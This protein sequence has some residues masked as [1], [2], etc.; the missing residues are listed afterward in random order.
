MEMPLGRHQGHHGPMGAITRLSAQRDAQAFATTANAALEELRALLLQ[1]RRLGLFADGST[2]G[3]G[4]GLETSDGQR[5]GGDW[6]HP[7]RSI[8]R[9][10]LSAAHRLEDIAQD[11]DAGAPIAVPAMERMRLSWAVVGQDGAALAGLA[12]TN[13]N[14]AVA[15]AESA[16][17]QDIGRML[18]M[19]L[20]RNEV[21]WA[22]VQADAHNLLEARRPVMNA[23]GLALLLGAA[24]I[25]GAARYLEQ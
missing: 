21:S 23:A 25:Y 11:L 24:A 4:D 16:Q 15:S 1:G 13:V 14:Q 5:L 22:G 3:N 18:Y 6:A 7:L 8:E 9:D 19:A 17:A 10:A 2:I 12:A 20:V